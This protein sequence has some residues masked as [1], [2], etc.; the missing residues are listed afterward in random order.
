MPQ[1]GKE[2][3]MG[4]EIHGNYDKCKSGSYWAPT[5]GLFGEGSGS[6]VGV[7]HVDEV[8]LERQVIKKITM[9]QLLGLFCG[10]GAFREQYLHRG[11]ACPRGGGR[12]GAGESVLPNK[13]DIAW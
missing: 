10:I 7:I 8:T 9:F 13:A 4:T 5:F 1:I 12:K 11:T 2:F 6:E 3:C